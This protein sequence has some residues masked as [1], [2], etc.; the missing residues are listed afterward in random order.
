MQQF[1]FRLHPKVEW[2]WYGTEFNMWQK[3][4][5]KIVQC[6][7]PSHWKSGLT[8]YWDGKGLQESTLEKACKRPKPTNV[9]METLVGNWMCNPRVQEC[10]IPKTQIWELSAHRW[11]FKV[12]RWD[13]KITQGRREELEE[14]NQNDGASK[15][16]RKEWSVGQKLKGQVR[17]WLRNVNWF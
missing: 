15:F 17:W 6:F 7:Y 2:I 3:R 10:S 5:V 9:Q 13:K 1:D 11:I 16:Q 4:A 8:I 12:L 14:E